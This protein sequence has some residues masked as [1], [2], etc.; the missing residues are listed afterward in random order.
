MSYVVCA[1]RSRA[2]VIRA[3][4]PVSMA[5]YSIAPVHAQVAGS[6]ELA[7]VVITA[8]PLDQRDEREVSQPVSVLRGSALRMR[9]GGN[10]GAT[11]DHELG[12]TSSAYGQGAG[13]PII[14]GM[15]AA[16]VRITESG[17]G[18]ADVSNASPD[19]RVAADTFNS[20][21]VEI[22]R[23]PSTLLYGSGAMGGLVNIVSNRIPLQQHDDVDAALRLRGSSAERERAVAAHIESALSPSTM[24]RFEGFRQQTGDYELAKPLRDENGVV[25]ANDRLPNS[26]TDT[27]SAAVGAS[28][29]LSGGAMVGAAIQTYRSNYGIPN[30]DEPVDIKLERVR[31]DTRADVPRPFAGF[32]ALRLKVSHTDYAHREIGPDGEQ[33]ARF[34]NRGVEARLELPHAPLGQWKGV[35]GTQIGESHMR[36]VGEGF[37]PRTRSLTLALFVVEERRLDAWRFELGGRGER[38]EYA[39]RESDESGARKP[40]RG[41]GLFSTSASAFYS[42][43]KGVEAGL[44]GT[45]AQRAPSAEE[46]YFEGAHPATFAY[47]VGNAGLRKERA[48]NLELAL[49]KTEGVVRAK[50]AVFDNRFNDYIYGTFD[51]STFDVLD[52]NG[53]VEET[54][55]VL[56]YRQDNARFRG[57]EA[58]ASVGEST[59]WNARVWGDMVRAT[60]TSGPNDGANV[61]RISPARIGLD[62]GYRTGAWSVLGSIVRTKRQDRVSSFDVRDGEPEQATAGYTFVNLGADYRIRLG[63]TDLT[64]TLQGRNLTNEDARVHT[65][66]LKNLAPLP[67]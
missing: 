45:L 14:R 59:G 10:L 43:T 16:R 27:R 53:N 24:W 47:E 60:I 44:T 33:G 50:L 15:D 56:R 28:A 9:E 34:E 11:L 29:F 40:S 57:L 8:S 41:F 36:G 49:R 3:V 48:R 37:L 52:E 5:L 13:R 42:I 61:P 4:I 26:E 17:M 18:V 12:V 65:S 30:P 23:G 21:Q 64:L 55:S 62:V 46:L 1:S 63:V 19:H 32:E 25:I 58:E 39:V 20:D 51:G 54:L 31:I 6:T 66:Y 22:L 67:G 38:E 2:R 7:P 35:L